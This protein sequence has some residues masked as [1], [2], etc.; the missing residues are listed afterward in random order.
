MALPIFKSVGSVSTDNG[1]NSL[2]GMPFNVVSG[3]QPLL[4][5]TLTTYASVSDPGPVPFFPNMSIQS[6]PSD[7]SGDS[8]INGTVALSNGSAVVTGTGTSF[9]SKL[10]PGD[11]IVFGNEATE[12]TVKSI[13][14]DTQLTLAQPYGGALS[15]GV[16]A[17]GPFNRPPAL[18][19]I[20]TDYHGLVMVRNEATGGIAKLYEYYQVD[21]SDGGATWKSVGG[22]EWDLT[23]GAQRLDGLASSTASGLPI[24]PF[25]VTY[26]E[27]ATN[28]IDHPLR[29]IIGTGQSMNRE[30][31]PALSNAYTGS[32]TTGIPMGARLRLSDAWYNANIASFPP[33]DQSILNA[34]HT[35]GGIVED[36]TN[37]GLWIDGTNDD[38]WSTAVLE[39]LQTIPDS[40]FQVLDTIK[41]E[42]SFT[43]P[44]TGQPGVAQSFN[45]QYLIPANTN[46]SADVYLQYSS[47]GGATWANASMVTVNPANE[48]PL[49]LTWTPA[50]AGT[51][52]VQTATVGVGW[53]PPTPIT[54]TTTSSADS[55]PPTVPSN[56]ALAIP[57]SS[58]LTATWTASTDNV[59]VAGYYLDVATDSSFA[60]FVAGYHNKSLGNVLSALI[61]GLSP[62]TT[63]YARVRAADASGNLSANSAAASAATSSSVARTVTS[64][65]SGNWSNPATWGGLTPPGA[66]DIVLINNNVTV[67]TNTTIGDGSNSTVLSVTNGTLTV[68]GAT[69]TIRGQSTFGKYNNGNGVIRLTVESSGTTPAGIVLDGN[70]GVSPVISTNN[71]TIISITGTPSARCFIETLAGTA[72]NPGYI[73]NCGYLDTGYMVAAY[74]DFSRLG[75][76]STPGIYAPAIAALASGQPIFSFDHC[77]IDSCGTTPYLVITTGTAIVSLTNSVWTN[78]VASDWEMN[79]C[80]YGTP[81]TTGTRLVNNCEF[82]GAA[83]PA[84]TGPQDFTITNCYFD[85]SLYGSKIGQWAEFDGNFI[86]KQGLN[87]TQM[88]GDVTN[89]YFLNDPSNK[90]T[91]TT[92][93]NVPNDT[94]SQ[95]A[96]NVF[97]YVGARHDNLA[98]VITEG[99]LT[100]HTITIE[101]NIILPNGTDTSASLGGFYA[102]TKDVGTP[103]LIVQHN[104]VDVGSENGAAAGF[105]V[106][107][108]AGAILSFTSNIFWRTGAPL[109]GTYALVN[110]DPA[111]VADIVTAANCDYNG[112]YDLATVPAGTWNDIADGTVYSVPTSGT[113]PP[114]V[115]D[116]A[117]VDPEFTDPTRNLQTWDASL[118]GPGT[119]A[120]AF[121]LIQQN[122]ALT[123]SSLLPYIQT[124]FAPTNPAYEGTGLGGTDIGA[125]PP[126]FNSA[127][128]AGAATA[129]GVLPSNSASAQ[130][131][132]L[133]VAVA[134]IAGSSGGTIAALQAVAV[135]ISY[136]PPVNQ[137]KA[138]TGNTQKGHVQG[139]GT[140][141][142]ISLALPGSSSIQQVKSKYVAFGSSR[143]RLFRAIPGLVNGE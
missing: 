53:I 81:I 32:A 136:I 97:Q 4:P 29:M 129:P 6:W 83:P 46:F 85:D 105:F 63:Y 115:H 15:T 17:F 127:D 75:N 119:I 49:T 123:K 73:T 86:R 113:T 84:W 134:P 70:A 111:P 106:G 72:G 87:E 22:A 135:Q 43:G 58:T 45:I 126:D 52:I 112:W 132:T 66:G 28:T 16:T 48:G 120:D 91:P 95:V 88:G 92:F 124:G 110:E 38:R 39:Q 60:N 76:A 74:T 55:Q 138:S 79:L 137:M 5:L 93:M 42:L 47:D 141:N 108:K 56:V 133:T 80:A 40:A 19:D 24:A 65:Q 69:L 10:L 31:W 59:G 3:N 50:A 71:D 36:M 9:D 8:W 89:S 7:S 103:L 67:T 107:E 18:G 114:G 140:S 100:Q 104:T 77:T 41:P 102:N 27:A 61:T 1:G 12:Y 109:A 2:Y 57:S 23:T 34:L 125:V 30:V 142:T 33:I 64:T 121:A 35:Y 128:T 101:N 13:H 54:F 62:S 117:N 37:S 11:L 14:S 26:D 122:P 143:D 94:N 96:N 118:G 51:Y 20:N 99:G 68:I 98:L 116:V 82:F 131:A 139:A 44:T 25:L 130:S 90:T 21:S 78:P